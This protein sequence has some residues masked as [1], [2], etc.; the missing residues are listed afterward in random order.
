[1]LLDAVSFLEF[2]GFSPQ[3]KGG[4]QTWDRAAKFF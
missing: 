1:M 2:P 4:R 3:G